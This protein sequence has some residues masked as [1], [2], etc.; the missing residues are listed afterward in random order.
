MF[1]VVLS[2]P[3][4]SFLIK[5]RSLDP[6]L[7]KRLFL[8]FALLIMTAA[9]LIRAALLGY[10]RNVTGPLNLPVLAFALWELTGEEA[11]RLEALELYAALAE[12]TPN[13]TYHR[14]LSLLRADEAS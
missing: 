13:A 3:P 4:L 12:R 6:F 8:L 5:A 10:F 1:F 7:P 9:Y 14:R 11:A 2:I